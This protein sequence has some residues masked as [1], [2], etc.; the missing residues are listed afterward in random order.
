MDPLTMFQVVGTAL[1]IGDI[2]VRC[3]ASLSSLK[4]K[5]HNAPIIVSAMIG[6]LYMV[7]SAL[8]QLSVLK[9]PESRRIPRYQELASQVH[10]ALDS[11]GPLMKALEEVLDRLEKAA[12]LEMGTKSRMVFLWSEKDMNHF[13]TF[14][15]R[16][17]N[18]LNLLLQAIQCQTLAQQRE[19]MDREESQ[20]ILQLAQDYSSSIIGLD[21]TSSFISEDTSG[22][23]TRFDF[24]PIIL[25][26]RL[27]QQAE[28]S[29]LR[30]AIRAGKY[31]EPNSVMQAGE[32]YNEKHTEE[33]SPVEL[34]DEASLHIA[35]LSLK[36]QEEQLES[37]SDQFSPGP[38]S[39]TTPLS[40]ESLGF[41]QFTRRS[42]SLRSMKLNSWWRPFQR[43]E[44]D[45]SIHQL[46]GRDPRR[47][48]VLGIRESG[49]T[50]LYR[51]LSLLGQPNLF[52]ERRD[53]YS[54][55]IRRQAIESIR[56]I[57]EAMER[58]GIPL[59]TDVG[60]EAANAFAETFCQYGAK[61]AT[62]DSLSK[63]FGGVICSLWPDD[64][65]QSAYKRRNEYQLH[66]N[67]AY[68][69]E[70]INRIA[71]PEYVPTNEDILR[72]KEAAGKPTES[73]LEYMGS[74][75][76]IVDIPGTRTLPNVCES[77]SDH[78][79][80][81][82]FT[83]D[84]TAYSRTIHGDG[85]VDHM[86]E[87]MSLF[88]STVNDRRYLQT[89][90]VV[91]ITKIDLLEDYL[92]DNDASKYLGIGPDTNTVDKYARYL[93]ARL[94]NMIVSN[95]VRERTRV[96]RA[97]LV[98]VDQHTSALGITAALQTLAGSCSE[99]RRFAANT[100]LDFMS[101]DLG[102]RMV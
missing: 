17:V 64:G 15:D 66:D 59:K 54:R 25:R 41:G 22:I 34:S 72:T 62:L 42:K 91:V 96:V 97:N 2:V 39:P 98:D 60:A 48:L 56:S 8:D 63:E 84:P 50:T 68:F 18:A 38:S 102:L 47:V 86:Q 79:S 33:N 55:I 5:Y 21:D 89:D 61:D 36:R 71:A 20:S 26:S 46:D 14:L 73:V 32:R 87:Q 40:S 65:F 92:R 3:I 28:R 44:S 70:S 75:Y 49:K 43:R 11:F 1:S 57:L 77:T 76:A 69:F 67:A 90:F 51:A 74:K 9:S 80:T 93:E 88:E 78:I 16:Q 45:I 58:L 53:V 52:A 29:H 85:S 35:G 6:Q 95:Q 81:I 37:T 99:K 24:D 27:Y 94:L 13:S 4:S 83:I 30:Q 101:S 100:F 19:I 7:Q 31:P 12:P 23:S 82:L 10:H